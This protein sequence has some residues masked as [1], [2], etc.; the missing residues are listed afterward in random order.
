MKSVII[1]NRIA[2]R[3]V[4]SYVFNSKDYALFRIKCVYYTKYLSR[5]RNVVLN[6]KLN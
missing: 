2:K 1:A 4:M 5:R 3:T 6:T